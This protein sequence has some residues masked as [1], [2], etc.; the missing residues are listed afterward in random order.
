MTGKRVRIKDV[1]EIRDDDR[2]MMITE[3][4]QTGPMVVVDINTLIDDDAVNP[5]REIIIRRED[6]KSF[7]DI[8]GKK[9]RTVSVLEDMVTVVK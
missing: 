9:Y 3:E 4:S 5:L 8:E 2:L 1:V 6:R 7:E